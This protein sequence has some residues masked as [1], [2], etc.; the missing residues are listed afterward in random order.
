MKPIR[1]LLADDHTVMREGLVLLI[2]SQHD[3]QVVAQAADGQEACKKARTTKPD[4]AV[5]DLSMPAMNGLE[6]AEALRQECPQ[7]KVL[8]LSMHADESY[9]RELVKARAAGYVLKQS[10]GEEL[11]QAIRQVA[12]GGVHF[13]HALATRAVC[14]ELAKR[15]GPAGRRAGSLTEKE[16]MVLRLVARG[17]TNKEVAAQLEL[18]PKTVEAYKARFGRKLGLHGRAEMVRYALRHGWL[19]EEDPTA[20]PV[21]PLAN[22]RARR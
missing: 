5:L 6:A 11:L 20:L 10:A 2:N 4:V 19:K 1:V 3:M 13:D 17:Y 12:K 15:T 18:S 22:V 9:L 16:E 21:P 7:V 8:A 14:E